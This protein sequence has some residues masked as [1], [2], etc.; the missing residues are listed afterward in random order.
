MKAMLRAALAALAISISSAALAVTNPNF[1][2]VVCETIQ[3]PMRDGTLLA[4]DKYSPA[5]GGRHPVIMLR[6]PYGHLIGSGCFNG[7]GASIA[8]FAQ[9]GYY[10]LAQ[11]CRGTDRAQGPFREMVQEAQDG[12]DAIQWAGTQSWSTGKVGTTSGSYLGL[13]QW[14]PAIHTPPHLAAINPQITASDYHDN[15]QYVNGVFDLWFG[16]SWPALA[17][18]GDQIQRFGRA[19]QWPPG[20]ADTVE[21]Q[22][23]AN[24]N[25]NLATKWV[26][27]LP[28][29]GFDQ[30]TTMAPY[31]YD[32][33][34]HPFY[35]AFWAAL[36]VETRYRDVK[37]PALNT[38][39]WYDIFQVGAFKNY[40]G[41][42]T[43]A[44]TMA[45][46]AGTKLYVGAYGHA[47]DSGKPTFGSDAALLPIDTLVAYYD[48][49]LKGIDNGWE[50]T[51]N[52]KMY[53][54]VPPD[55]GNAGSG[56]YVT[57]ASYPLPGSETV[58]LYLAS[59]GH[60]NTSNGDGKLVGAAPEDSSPDRFAYDP[61][62]PAPTTG[63]NMCCNG[64][65]LA[66]GAQDQG[67]VELRNDVLVY[68]TAA[69]PHD[70]AVIGPVEVTLWARSSAPDTDFTAKLVDVHLD[71]N[72]HNVLDRVVRAS[73]RAGSKLPPSNIEP[74]EAY[75]YTIPVGN[76]GTIFKKGHHIRLEISSSNFPHY[77][78]NLNTGENST[79]TSDT[80]V[81]HQ[82]ILHDEGHPS[83]LMIFVAPGV[84][85]P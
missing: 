19:S 35:D 33:V 45:A 56:F 15:W 47:G 79:W 2:G 26:W 5:G 63:G 54:L 4:T 14:Q 22:W 32:W 61:A 84:H 36:D 48:R 65:L 66:N 68:T 83:R 42:R 12:Q 3:V 38:T 27:Q 82:T 53:V 85:A 41:M 77:A 46:R 18:V 76:A 31:F 21:G 75:E 11:E 78:R 34:D 57:G 60:A 17:F 16:M 24:V 81:A 37:V 69:L 73:L 64:V 72:S 7:L 8:P 59:H 30:F 44:G 6:N 25:A 49:Y 71:G 62:N 52:V 58:S 39:A 43:S 51:P 13:T 9:H 28:L 40:Q 70:V 50:E 67:K 1:P 74:G 10:A 29:T 80:A 20:Q 23:N 55:T